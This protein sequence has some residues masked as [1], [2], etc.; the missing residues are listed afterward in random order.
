M[1]CGW[2]KTSTAIARWQWDVTKAADEQIQP[3]SVMRLPDG[4]D[5]SH[6]NN[7]DDVFHAWNSFAF[8]NVDSTNRLN[9]IVLNLH[10]ARQ[11]AGERSWKS[12][13]TCSIR[14]GGGLANS[15]TS[16]SAHQI[17][18]MELKNFL[19]NVIAHNPAPSRSRWDLLAEEERA[20]KC[21]SPSVRRRRRAR[22][23]SRR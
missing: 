14:S 5:L 19:D 12:R 4:G 7:P 1:D 2:S 15:V 16:C 22:M 20:E 6:I 13:T 8:R 18:N 9:E 11:R 3:L 10:P 17:S 21:L 23:P